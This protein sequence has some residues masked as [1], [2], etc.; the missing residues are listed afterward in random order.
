MGIKGNTWGEKEIQGVGK[1]N[2]IKTFLSLHTPPTPL[3]SHNP[4]N[5]AQ[6]PF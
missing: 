4:I 6:N 1:E 2:F 3:T 5:M